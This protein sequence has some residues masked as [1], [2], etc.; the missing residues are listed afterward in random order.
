[1]SAT[2]TASSD[3]LAL[4]LDDLGVGDELDLLAALELVDQVARHRLGRDRRRGSSGG[5]SRRAGRGTSPPDR[6]SCRRRRSAPGRRRTA[7]PRPASRRSTPRRPRSASSSGTGELAVLGA[8]GDDDR[9]AVDL[10]AVG[11]LDRVVAVVG[12]AAPTAS[13]GTTI[14][15]PK[16]LAWIFA[17]SASSLPEMP[18]REAQ[19]VLDPRRGAGLATERDRVDRLRVEALGGAVHARPPGPAGPPPTTTRSHIAAAAPAR[20]R[21]R[22]ASATPALDGLR[23]TPRAPDHHRRL[24]TRRRPSPRSSDSA[25]SSASRSTQWWGTRLRARNSRNRRV[26]AS[27]ASRSPARRRRSRS[28]ATGAPGTR[29]GSGC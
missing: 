7:A 27:S 3:G 13:A 12:V 28:A 16:R 6:P 20:A 26:S 18:G 10:L 21:G 19:V 14:R 5:S 29:G 15:A 22:A 24:A 4:E 23:S 11:Q 25:S 8:G 17:R 9:P 2:T 1:M